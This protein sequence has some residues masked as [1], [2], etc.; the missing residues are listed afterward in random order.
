MERFDEIL[1]EAIAYIRQPNLVGGDQER[2]ACYDIMLHL[3]PDLTYQTGWF[4]GERNTPIELAELILERNEFSHSVAEQV[5]WGAY[6][7][8]APNYVY[9]DTVPPVP[10][11]AAMEEAEQWHVR[12]MEK[13]SGKWNTLL[14]RN[15]SHM[16]WMLKHLEKLREAETQ[17]F[18]TLPPH[19]KLVDVDSLEGLLRLSQPIRVDDHVYLTAIGVTGDSR[20]ADD[21]TMFMLKAPLAPGGRAEV[22][23]HQALGSLLD[24]RHKDLSLD[25]Y[26]HDAVPLSAPVIVKD[27]LY[28]SPSGW[29]GIVAFPLDGSSPTHLSFKSDENIPLFDANVLAASDDEVFAFGSGGSHGGV[30]GYLPAGNRWTTIASVRRTAKTTLLD[31]FDGDYIRSPIFDMARHRLLITMFQNTFGAMGPTVTGLYSLD[32]RDHTIRKHYSFLRFQYSFDQVE[33]GRFWL[34]HL[35]GGPDRKARLYEYRIDEELWR[36]VSLEGHYLKFFE[37]DQKLRDDP[38]K[39]PYRYNRQKGS[40]QNPY[41]PA[42]GVDIQNPIVKGKWGIVPPFIVIDGWTWTFSP[43]QRIS[44][45]W[46]TVERFPD[47][48]N[49][50]DATYFRWRGHA[51][52][53]RWLPDRRQVLYGDHTQLW[54]IDAPPSPEDS[55]D[56][57]ELLGH[58]DMDSIDSGSVVDQ[59]GRVPGKLVGKGD[60][61]DGHAG[62]AL[63][64]RDAI[65]HLGD[66]KHLNISGPITLSAW[67]KPTHGEEGQYIVGRGYRGKA[68]TEVSLRIKDGFYVIGA[69]NGKKSSEATCSIPQSDFDQW[70]HLAGAYNGKTWL[71]YRNGYL[72]NTRS[73][74]FG[75]MKMDEDWAIGAHANGKRGFQGDIDDV[76]IYG[77]ALSQ[78][79][80]IA[81]MK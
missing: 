77:Q 68:D 63:H 2:A 38:K 19:R 26:C 57:L 51:K 34:S 6:G 56:D 80:I 5:L 50:P 46:S 48:L 42:E 81:A 72:E 69:W 65:L 40:R 36:I 39:G 10:G 66:P 41:M 20:G 18:S 1:S 71:L 14:P 30:F 3:W 61:V 17:A 47:L 55:A 12:I 35:D 7:T 70:V 13:T 23:S 21:G 49:G 29:G 16:R 74:E 45:D 59:T 32:T 22:V 52:S 75:P 28:C 25:R 53:L 60:L 27:V 24:S 76:R 58:W 8:T 11:Q 73:A 4:P 37:V 15:R 33:P 54:L 31:H 67:V 64:A 9:R 79:E 43:F 78:A 44:P 62:R